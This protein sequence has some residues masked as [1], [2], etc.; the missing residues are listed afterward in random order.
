MT[1]KALIRQMTTRFNFNGNARSLRGTDILVCVCALASSL[2][3]ACETRTPEQPLAHTKASTVYS[4]LLQMQDLDRGMT[5]CRIQNPW[6]PE[7]VTMQYLLIPDKDTA[8]FSQS[9][10]EDLE[11]D[12]G[13]MQVIVT[14]LQRQTITASCHARLL[15]DLGA[16]P[17]I[18]V[19]CDANYISA[20]DL[21][22]A[23]RNVPDGGLSVS[24]NAEVLLAANS[25]AIWISPYETNSRTVA[26]A[27]LPQ[28]PV[29]YCADYMETTPLG[30]AEWMRFYGRLVGLGERADSLFKIREAA[31]IGLAEAAA[32]AADSTVQTTKPADRDTAGQDNSKTSGSSNQ[33]KRYVLADFPYGA[34]WYV[35]GGRSTMSRLYQDAGF[36][37]PWA[38]DTH[39]G[40]LALSPEAVFAKA[41]NADCWIIKYYSPERDWTLQDFVSQSN[42]Y[43]QFRAA[44]SGSVYGCNTAL[45]DYFET[46][47]FRP[48]LILSEMRHILLQEDDSLQYFHRLSGR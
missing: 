2:F 14:P 44:Q 38:D 17:T 47:P 27:I 8:S 32:L 21:R 28:L 42:L 36:V 25:D 43:S 35:P 45:S 4:S 7:Q 40:S 10:Y 46:A 3:F 26:E 20:P 39:G 5:L 19:I 9:D 15:Q 13:P 23:L 33:K 31:Y 1:T 37:Y 48:D 22:E 29:I 18:G 11:K 34:T 6:Q 41:Q 30:R 12:F 24:P 16:L